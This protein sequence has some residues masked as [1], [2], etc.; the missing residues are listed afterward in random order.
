MR[1]LAFVLCA[2]FS[3]PAFAQIYYLPVQYQHTAGCETFYYGGTNPYLYQYGVREATIETIRS[4]QEDFNHRYARHWAVY[5]DVFPYR[6]M[7]VYG[8]TAAD[9]ANEANWN[10]PRY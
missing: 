2:L 1:A 6:D 9:A 8:F 5:S 4:N 7:T 10:Q 3:A